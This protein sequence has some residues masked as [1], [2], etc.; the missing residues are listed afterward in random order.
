MAT[1]FTF[2]SA[3]ADDSGIDLPAMEGMGQLDAKMARVKIGSEG[4]PWSPNFQAQWEKWQSAE[5]TI[6]LAQG[7]LLRAGVCAILKTPK[8]VVVGRFKDHPTAGNSWTPPAGLWGDKTPLEAGLAELGQEVIVSREGAVGFW[9]FRGEI[10]EQE[11]VRRYAADHNMNVDDQ[12]IIDIELLEN[13]RTIQLWV[14]EE[15]E[16]NIVL[17]NDMAT[18]GLEFMF[19]LKLVDENSLNDITLLDGEWLDFS[20]SWRKSVVGFM[21]ADNFDQFM[22]ESIPQSK[23]EEIGKAMFN[24]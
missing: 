8:G 5:E 10:V 14:G 19:T 4:C 17:A 3:R 12:L 6:E 23:L 7:G 16:G 11:W 20:Q 22:A 15:F 9:C 21:N 24:R 1:I 13:E 2:N 18:G